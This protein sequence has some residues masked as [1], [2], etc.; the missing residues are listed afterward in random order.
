[1]V[2]PSGRGCSH[3]VKLVNRLKPIE[4]IERGEVDRAWQMIFL[5]RSGTPS[6]LGGRQPS[7]GDW[8]FPRGFEVADYRSQEVCPTDRLAGVVVAARVEAFLTI[9]GHG[10]GG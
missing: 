6:R 2:K 9:V 3:Q 8:F 4:V 1:M 7:V 10:V 5:L